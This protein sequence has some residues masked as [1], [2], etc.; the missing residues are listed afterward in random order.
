M[1][2]P[3]IWTIEQ[4]RAGSP[5]AGWA[6]AIDAEARAR[7]RLGRDEDERAEWAAGAWAAV[8]GEADGSVNC[9]CVYRRGYD[10]AA[11]RALEEGGWEAW[12][13][14]WREVDER[15]PIGRSSRYGVRYYGR[16]D[17]RV[18]D[19]IA[20]LRP[21]DVALWKALH[22]LQAALLRWAIYRQLAVTD[23]D[24]ERAISREFGSVNSGRVGGAH[25]RAEGCR[26][27]NDSGGKHPQ[28]WYDVDGV[29]EPVG[30]SAL[31]RRVRA[32]LALP[33]PGTL[34]L[35]SGAAAPTRRRSPAPSGPPRPAVA[36]AEQ[37]ALF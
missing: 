22:G 37:C 8:R 1:P 20:A 27:F 32:L 16:D 10:W 2:M 25:Y 11:S 12:H 26:L 9:C 18:P 14:A 7:R 24:L 4:I 21:I 5:D 33:E 13:L 19:D 31:V 30:G 35:D 36:G 3:P 15:R 23:A 6:E 17:E 28:F 29:E 34:G